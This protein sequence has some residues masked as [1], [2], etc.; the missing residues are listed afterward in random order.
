MCIALGLIQDPDEL[1]RL[2]CRFLLPHMGLFQ[3]LCSFVF[4]VGCT[5]IHDHHIQRDVHWNEHFNSLSF[6]HLTAVVYREQIDELVL[7]QVQCTVIAA[8][9]FPHQVSCNKD[10]L[11][12]STAIR[13]TQLPFQYAHSVTILPSK[14]HLH[15][16]N[17]D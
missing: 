17:S 2:N 5:V 9:S 15:V 6:C 13:Y 7:T 1:V 16:P 8:A 3:E 14:P 11:A 12:A 4:P 10:L